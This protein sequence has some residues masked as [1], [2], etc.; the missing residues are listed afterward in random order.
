MTSTHNAVVAARSSRWKL[1]TSHASFHHD[2]TPSNRSSH[3]DDD[4]I[5]QH[6]HHRRQLSIADQLDILRLGFIPTASSSSSSSSSKDDE[7][8]DDEM[9][10][11]R[12]VNRISHP[13]R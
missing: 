4:S 10:S 11:L 5:M 1:N 8:G 12:N 3:D 2:A 13:S 7:N 6:R 9:K